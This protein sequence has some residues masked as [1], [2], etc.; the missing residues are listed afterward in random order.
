MLEGTFDSAAGGAEKSSVIHD[1][2]YTVW[3][4]PSET[5]QSLGSSL[6]V[7][8]FSSFAYIA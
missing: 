5:G 8:W 7:S 2:N 1:W 6:N 4:R 3:P